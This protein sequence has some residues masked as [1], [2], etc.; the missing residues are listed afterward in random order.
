MTNGRRMMAH[1]VDEMTWLLDAFVQRVGHQARAILATR[2]GLT[3]CYS[4]LERDAAHSLGA[5][6]SGV[7]SLGNGA[8]DILA[9]PSG[10]VRQ[11]V[12]EHDGFLL[13]VTS[14]GEGTLLAVAT[15]PE[16][17]AGVVGHEM[18]QLVRSVGE[19]LNSSDRN[20]DTTTD[21]GGR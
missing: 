2:D 14:A 4:G 18:G 3:Q 21:R 8:A 7:N 6:V 5:L 10:R 15:T 20:A 1:Q 16:A 17:R 19:H 12:I 13:F 11:T 9:M